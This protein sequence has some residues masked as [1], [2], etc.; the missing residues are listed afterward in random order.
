MIYFD[1]AATTFPKPISVSRAVY[2]SLQRCGNPGRG[3]H[4]LAMRAADEIYA[5]RKAAADMFNSSPERVIFTSGATHALNLAIGAHRDRD[6]AILISDLE[7]NSVL[8]PARA[9]GKEVRVFSSEI[10]LYGEE[11]TEGILHSIDSISYGA[12]MLI[13]TAASNICGATMPIREIGEYCRARGILF[14]VD[15]AQA[16]GVYD[17]DMERDMIDVL[18]LPGHKGL[19]GP[20]GC[21]LMILGADV[22]I[23]PLM[24][25]GS[26]VN[27][28]ASGMP[29]LPPERY[30]AGTLPVPLIVGL[31]RGIEFVKRKTPSVILAHE[32]K[33]ARRLKG[34]L[35]STHVHV[36]VPHHDG[37]IV[38][39]NIEGVA[40]EEVSSRLNALGICTRAGLHCAP[41]AHDALGSTGAVR[42]SFGVHNTVAEVRELYRAL[43][44]IR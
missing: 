7:H 28:R 35:A 38:L 27:S 29:E 26:G 3:A 39:F 6:G 25:G 42:V 20:M 31:A 12:S 33:L 14:I 40:S 21:G 1:N 16:G 11:R 23:P 44:G 37:G 41:L 19:Y 15:G 32:Q 4:S 30:E 18:C 10:E 13:T 36:Y 22:C 9:S 2:D 24:Y 8:R 43:M 34:A 5:C 17:I